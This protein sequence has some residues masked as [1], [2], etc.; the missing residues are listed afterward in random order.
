MVLGHLTMIEIR[1]IASFIY[2]D[3]PQQ[4]HRFFILSTITILACLSGFLYYAFT[5]AEQSQLLSYS[6]ESG[7]IE[8]ST[9]IIFI[10]AAFIGLVQFIKTNAKIDFIFMVLMAFAAAREMDWHKEWTTDSILK[11]RFYIESSTPMIEKIIGGLVIAFLIYALWQLMKRV[12][13]FVANLWHFAPRAWAIGF[14][15]GALTIAKI[16]DSMER[17]IP[18]LAQFHDD[19]YEL[20]SVVEESLEITGAL[21]FILYAILNL[22]G[23]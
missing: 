12:P 7:A 15:L 16:L 1:Q 17:I 22:K 23:R 10:L 4:M 21:F 11:S 19:H 3:Y 9:A 18:P 6:A 20:I 2:N 14:G 5:H 13:L 8:L